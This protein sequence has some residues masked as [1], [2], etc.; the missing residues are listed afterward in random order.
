MSHG[1]WV[2]RNVS[3]HQTEQGYLQQKRRKDVLAEVDRLSQLDPDCLPAES[4]Y[5]LEIDFSAFEK[6]TLVN[7]TYWLYSMRAACKAGRRAA[8]RAR[9]ATPRTAQRTTNSILPASRVSNAIFRASRSRYVITGALATLNEINIDWGLSTPP[10]RKRKSTSVI[11]LE[12][13]D[14]RRRKPD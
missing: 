13:R 6:D 12:R 7:Q 14:T 4:K 11:S 1:Q 9:R 8:T 5:L 2:F 3:L 10:P